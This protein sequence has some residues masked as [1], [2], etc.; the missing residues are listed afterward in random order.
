[1]V[2]NIIHSNSTVLSTDVIRVILKNQWGK[3]FV[4]FVCQMMINLDVIKF[5]FTCFCVYVVDLLWFLFDI[6]VSFKRELVYPV[7][8]IRIFVF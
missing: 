2:E 4:N 3:S 1:M 7:A 8:L 6:A 5:I